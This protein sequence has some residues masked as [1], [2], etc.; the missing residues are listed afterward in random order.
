MGELD[1][2]GK[3]CYPQ[4]NIKHPRPFPGND[5]RI[6]SPPSDTWGPGSSYAWGAST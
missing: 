3:L 1:K 4:T 2:I 5:Y 6:P